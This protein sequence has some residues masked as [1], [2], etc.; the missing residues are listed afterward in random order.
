VF[1]PASKCSRV[2]LN[3]ASTE[4]LFRRPDA[5]SSPEQYAIPVGPTGGATPQA[6]ASRAPKCAPRGSATTQD[7][8]NA[9]TKTRR[10]GSSL[11]GWAGGITR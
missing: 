2:A 6:N 5:S 8:A 11:T 10:G 9:A 7:A 3:A 1:P 4:A